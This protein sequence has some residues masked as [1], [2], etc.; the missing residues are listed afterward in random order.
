MKRNVLNLSVRAYNT[1]FEPKKV[2][3]TYKFNSSP[4]GSHMKIIDL[5]GEKKKVLDVGCATGY[6]DEYLKK[7][8]C[9]VAGIEIDEEAAKI[10]RNFCDEVIVGDVEEIEELDYPKA[11]FDVI[12]YADIL[13]HIKRPDILLIK[14]RDYLAPNG[15]VVA[16]IPN[17]A[18]FSTRLRL[19][20]G[21]FK[22]KDAGIIDKTHLRFFTLKTTKHLFE[23]ALYKVEKIDYTGNFTD[24]LKLTKILP[25][26][27]ACQFIIVAR[28]IMT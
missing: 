14:F 12:I 13:E 23:N 28:P 8:S 17:V 9:Y 24:R 26:W 7:N 22:Y 15:Y 4:Y 21:K 18:R 16:S 27:F 25:T 5:V 3:E 20:F 11:F 2:V 10:A 1:M 6:L 19:L